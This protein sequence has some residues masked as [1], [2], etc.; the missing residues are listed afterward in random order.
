M[1]YSRDQVKAMTQY[2]YESTTCK[3]LNDAG[4]RQEFNGRQLEYGPSEFTFGGAIIFDTDAVD[5]LKR[6]GLLDNGKCPMCSLREDDLMY[7]LQSQ[8]SGAIYHRYHRVRSL[9]S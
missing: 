8:Q 5:Y 6:V 2:E 7:K 4:F 9:T 1:R 3:E